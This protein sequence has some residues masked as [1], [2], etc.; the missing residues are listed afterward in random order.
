MFYSCTINNVANKEV[1][2]LA[3]HQ[4]RILL[5]HRLSS[6]KDWGMRM[7]VD[8]L[9]D[10][11]PE[12]CQLAVETL[13]EA[14]DNPECLDMLLKLRPVLDHLGEIAKPIF[15]RYFFIYLELCHNMFINRFLSSNQGFQNILDMDFVHDEMES[16]MEVYT[17][18][19]F[20]LIEHGGSIKTL[21]M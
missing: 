17:F 3:L 14:C 2:L 5:H 20:C 12:I 13:D 4:L 18:P 21:N 1:R 19:L 10:L 11:E 6:F 16:W 8:Q 7:L 9:Y 15:L